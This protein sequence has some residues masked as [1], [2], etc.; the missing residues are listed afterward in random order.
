MTE[1][2]RLSHLLGLV[3]GLV[4]LVVGVLGLQTVSS[5]LRSNINKYFS[6]LQ[7]KGLLLHLLDEKLLLVSLAGLESLSIV[8]SQLLTMK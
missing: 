1:T 3:H 5:L 6:H 4:H 8:T 7:S 2:V